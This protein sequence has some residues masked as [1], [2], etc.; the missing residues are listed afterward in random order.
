M[1]RLL[2]LGMLLGLLTGVSVAQRGRA[3]GAVSPTARPDIDLGARRSA[4]VSPTLEPNRTITNRN[5][6][7]TAGPVRDPKVD[8]TTTIAPSGTSVNR[9]VDP[10]AA[11]IRDP[12][13]GVSSTAGGNS[14]TVNRNVSPTAAAPIRDP[15]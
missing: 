10:T 1:K 3:G 5:V 7:P 12:L 6:S 11:P 4:G 14:T 8:R 9:N 15:K 13:A 2:I